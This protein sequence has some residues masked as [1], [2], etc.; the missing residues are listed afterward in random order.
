MSL[1]LLAA[2]VTAVGVLFPRRL[3]R[4]AWTSHAPRLAA[5][6]WLVTAVS[7]LSVA[8]LAAAVLVTPLH[9]LGDAF[10][11]LLQGCGWPP[12]LRA[13]SGPS[14]YAG[15]AI[16]SWMVGSTVSS[17]YVVCRAA[18]RERRRHRC[19]LHLLGEPAGTGVVVLDHPQPS[20]FCVPG[21]GGHIVLTRGALDVLSPAE[22]VAV[23][24][25]ERAH[26]SGR[27]HVIVLL[28]A[29]LATA[30]PRMPLFTLALSEVR[31]LV[32][33]AADDKALRRA[34]P[35]TLVQAV[36]RLAAPASAQHPATGMFHATGT[37]TTERVLRL[38]TPRPRRARLAMLSR[39]LVAVSFAATPL[40]AV[41]LPA[42]TDLASHCTEITT[43]R[44]PAEVDRR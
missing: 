7:V 14:E 11:L 29:I 24:A 41:A 22:L 21:D 37:A 6:T 3:A 34:T 1:A 31:R 4:A 19:D 44:P 18:R 32:E 38:V 16:I 5:G 33:L 13:P 39:L 2:Y 9:T 27:H 26:L 23:L 28:P 20:V 42:V 36:L 25:H 30:F 43:S 12:Q 8:L 10:V 35:A 17:G 40:A 15:L